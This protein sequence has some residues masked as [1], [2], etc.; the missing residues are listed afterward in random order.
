M[1]TLN[2]V[3]N[4]DT[5][6]GVS[7]MR[8]V[9]YKQ[10]KKMKD[11]LFV[12]DQEVEARID[13]GYPN[14]MRQQEPMANVVRNVFGTELLWSSTRRELHGR[15]HMGKPDLNIFEFKGSKKNNIVLKGGLGMY[16]DLHETNASR[17]YKMS[18]GAP[19]HL[20]RR[21]VC[22]ELQWSRGLTNW[23]NIESFN[24]AKPWKLTV[25][26]IFS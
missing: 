15:T 19:E 20:K 8:R 4:T 24:F 26:R 10:V 5:I 11:T 6:V 1:C 16:F 18:G 25:I 12:Q 22:T 7:T 13:N 2:L 21:S 14:V 3:L 23:N 17:R 9:A